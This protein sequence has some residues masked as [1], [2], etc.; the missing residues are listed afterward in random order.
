MSP[1][2]EAAFDPHERAEELL[3][4]RALGTL[5]REEQIELDA[6]L[7]LDPSLDDDRYELVAASLHLALVADEEPMPENLRQKVQSDAD[8]FFGAQQRV[9]VRSLPPRRTQTKAPR[10][11]WMW[12]SLA[13]AA[14]VVLLVWMGA[15]NF[16]SN[17]APVDGNSLYERVVA[18]SDLVRWDWAGT[19]DPAVGSTSGDVVWSSDIQQGVMKIGGL[20]A[21]DPGEFQYQLWIFDRTRDERYPVDGGVFDVPAGSDEIYVPIAAKLDVDTPYLFAITVEEPGGV[22]VSSRERIAFVAQPPANEG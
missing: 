16:A 4:S 19:E 13:T 9:D 2:N 8:V 12:Q 18:A 3:I 17:D 7:Q 14:V 15:T 1:T 6:L 21:N 11:S 5:D 10:P 20:A 22:V